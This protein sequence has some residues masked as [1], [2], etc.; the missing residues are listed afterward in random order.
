MI[1]HEYEIHNKFLYS[2]SHIVYNV[3]MLYDF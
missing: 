1:Q 2:L 3:A